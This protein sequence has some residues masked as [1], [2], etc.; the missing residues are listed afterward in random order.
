MDANFLSWLSPLLLALTPR[1][2]CGDFHITGSETVGPCVFLML[3]RP[4]FKHF[5]A[6]FAR[7]LCSNHLRS[8]SLCC[9]VSK[10]ILLFPVP[11]RPDPATSA[12]FGQ[13]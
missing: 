3:T 2:L 7:N 8:V 1:V 5:T 13:G 6:L 9:V 11:G 12:R 4:A 10:E